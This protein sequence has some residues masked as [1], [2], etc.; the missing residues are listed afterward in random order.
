MSVPLAT[1]SASAARWLR[2]LWVALACGCL[3]SARVAAADPGPA[4]RGGD[5]FDE[6]CAECHSLREGK[7]KKGPSLFA[8]VGRTAGSAAGYRYSAA[9]RRAALV[10]TAE[11]I[12]AYIHAPGKRVPGTRMKYDGL[13]D[14]QARADLIA[15]LQTLH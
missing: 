7:N 1:P 14:A 8:V 11:N 2:C 4:A 12:D 5:V 6:E 3:L 9:M 15:F 13:D 10:W